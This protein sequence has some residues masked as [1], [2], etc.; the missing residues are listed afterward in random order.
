MDA[1]TWVRM[2]SGVSW[3]PRSPLGAHVPMCTCP[4]ARSLKDV[5]A[6]AWARTRAAAARG[7]GGDTTGSRHLAEPGDS[8]VGVLSRSSGSG[9]NRGGWLGLGGDRGHRQF[10][11]SLCPVREIQAQPPR[12]AGGQCGDDDLVKLFGA[13]H[14]TDRCEWIGVAEV[15]AGLYLLS[16]ELVERLRKL[17]TFLRHGGRAIRE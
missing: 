7:L 3:T 2:D 4:R 1:A 15:A 10:E 16:S 12:N 17:S 9:G 13:Q 6:Q 14:I 5:S 11:L 8:V